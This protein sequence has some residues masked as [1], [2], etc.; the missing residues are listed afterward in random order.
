MR[1]SPLHITCFVD[2]TQAVFADRNLVCLTNLVTLL[3][4][5]VPVDVYQP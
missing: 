4:F 2:V 1:P 5:M 3:I